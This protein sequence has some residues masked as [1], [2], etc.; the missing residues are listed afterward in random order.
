[1][2][3]YQKKKKKDKYLTSVIIKFESFQ[4][5]K[6]ISFIIKMQIKIY[7]RKLTCEKEDLFVKFETTSTISGAKN[8]AKKL[9]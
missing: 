1:M 3:L 4:I 9:L 8:S 5:H 7:W 2:A 6:C